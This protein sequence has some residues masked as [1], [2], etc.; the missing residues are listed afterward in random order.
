LVNT[1]EM[2]RASRDARLTESCQLGREWQKDETLGVYNA[3]K[4]K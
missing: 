1:A 2:M 3:F 4:C